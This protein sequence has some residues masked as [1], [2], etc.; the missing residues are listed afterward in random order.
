MIHDIGLRIAQIRIIFK[1]PAHY[2]SFPHPLAY[3]EWFRPFTAREEVSGLFKATRSTRNR[4]R[5][6]EVVSVNAIL[7]PCHLTPKY[8][9]SAVDKLWTHLNVL[10]EGGDTFYLNH[11][12]NL[13]IFDSLQVHGPPA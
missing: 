1:L 4:G 12:N 9:S 6:S 10:E 2:G 5:H 11:Y 7:M 3:V 13:H 8:G